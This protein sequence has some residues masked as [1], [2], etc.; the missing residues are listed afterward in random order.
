MKLVLALIGLTSS[1]FIYA[2]DRL[3]IKVESITKYNCIKNRKKQHYYYRK[4]IHPTVLIGY[5]KWNFFCHDRNLF[6]RNDNYKFPRLNAEKDSFKLWHA[7]SYHFIDYDKSNKLDINELIEKRLF[8]EYNIPANLDMFMKLYWPESPMS[9]PLNMPVLGFFMLPWIDA[10]TGKDFCPNQEHYNG[11][12]PI[13]KILG[14]ILGRD[15]EAIY[16][17]SNNNQQDV[18]FIKESLLSKIGFK[19]SQTS[20]TKFYWPADILDPYNR[21]Q[22]QQDYSIRTVRE[23]GLENRLGRFSSQTIDY[24]FGCIPK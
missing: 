24:R 16:L 4:E 15:T 7:K 9:H 2:Q 8:K 6:G 14:D 3:P 19:D 5:G 22:G 18:I 10:M 13:L 17:A 21:H 23:L 11:S 1:T 12:R 20:R